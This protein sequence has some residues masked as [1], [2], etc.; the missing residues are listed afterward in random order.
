MISCYKGLYP[1]EHRGEDFPLIQ[2]VIREFRPMVAVEL[3]TGL[4]GFAALLADTL[5]E[6]GGRV[7]SFDVAIRPGDDLSRVLA[8]FDNVTFVRA[9]VL[10]MPHAW[11]T[12]LLNRRWDGSLPMLYCANGHSAR[13]MEIYAP[14]IMGPA[15][16]GCHDYDSHAGDKERQERA[17]SAAGF[18]PCRHAE[19]EALAH[20]GY[21][22][23]G[24]RFWSR[25]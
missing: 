25:A 13:E 1:C 4:G 2:S 12:V 23:V 16:L 8:A 21:P 22:I 14:W 7:Y 18:I 10:S 5:A 24:T 6:W 20:P 19:F 17:A 3:G 9:D 11:V 15:L